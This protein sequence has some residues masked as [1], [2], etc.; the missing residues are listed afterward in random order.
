MN[1]TTITPSLTTSTPPPTTT[2]TT[3]VELKFVD[4]N[5]FPLIY[6][7]SEEDARVLWS[8]G[9]YGKG[10]LSRGKPMCCFFSS[11]FKKVQGEEP[12][13]DK[14]PRASE[15]VLLTH[16][17]CFYLAFLSEHE[18]LS[19]T[20]AGKTREE[21]WSAFC[22]A[23]ARF[24]LLMAAYVHFRSKGWAPR[25]GLS[26][27]VDFLLYKPLEKH[28][29]AEYSVIVTDGNVAA[30]AAAADDFSW[31][32]LLRTSRNMV[33]VAKALVVCRVS[34]TDVTTPS[35][36]PDWINYTDIQTVVF[37]RWDPNKSR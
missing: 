21:C 2:T 12:P 26:H 31:A 6:V 13:P 19:I 34:S 28:T 18:N 27:G 33:S 5:G 10:S 24:P 17:E 14:R 22:K 4:C 16:A 11:S 20:V 36:S 37:S 8:L 25:T 32:R 35:E 3:I 29:H 9:W 15:D 1:S 7:G 30:A 23:N